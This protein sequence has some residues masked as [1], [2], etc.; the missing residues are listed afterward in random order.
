MSPSTG[1]LKVRHA[2]NGR[3]VTLP[4]GYVG[5]AT[6]LGYATT[7]HGA[8]GVTVDTMHGLAT[9]AES[10]QQLYTMLT[11]GRTA[12]HLYLPVVG[13]GDP[14]TIL[15]PENNE[16]RTATELLE[17][18]LARDATP[19]VC[20]HAAAGAARSCGPA[21]PCH[22]PLPRRPPRR[23]RTPRRSADDHQTRP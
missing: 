19:A 8:Q 22:R 9:G 7:V 2:Q 17:Q 1:A 14:H 5:T 15:R 21:R 18:I 23:S 12:N 10:R 13:D 3:M 6:E 16:L 4:L 11:R 20:D